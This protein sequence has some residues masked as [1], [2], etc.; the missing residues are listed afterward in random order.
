M[1]HADNGGPRVTGTTNTSNG[2]MAAF[3]RAGYANVTTTRIVIGPHPGAALDD[4]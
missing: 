2:P 4:R 1:M 3:R